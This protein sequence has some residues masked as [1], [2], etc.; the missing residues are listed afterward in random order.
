MAESGGR[1]RE[2]GGAY[3]PVIFLRPLHPDFLPRVKVRTGGIV[4]GHQELKR[5][6]QVSISCLI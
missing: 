4:P 6:V 3:Q 2:E 1:R 5:P